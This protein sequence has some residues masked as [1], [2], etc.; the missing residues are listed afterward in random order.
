MFPKHSQKRRN[1]SLKNTRN[2]KKRRMNQYKSHDLSPLSHN[3]LSVVFSFLDGNEIIK[4]S[5]IC[6]ELS[7]IIRKYNL[8][9]IAFHYN[10]I[11][12]LQF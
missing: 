5:K 6:E 11:L 9:N 4:V 8:I 10:M 3:S 7:E 12:L 1:T 2:N